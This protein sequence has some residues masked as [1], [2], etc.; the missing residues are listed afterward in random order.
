VEQ[1]EGLA[2]AG[3]QSGK[4]DTGINDDLQLLHGGIICNTTTASN[5]V[6]DGRTAPASADAPL[7]G[8]SADA[9]VRSSWTVEKR[10]PSCWDYRSNSGGSTASFWLHKAIDITERGLNRWINWNEKNACPMRY[11]PRRLAFVWI[12]MTSLPPRDVSDCCAILNSPSRITRPF[13][14]RR[15]H[16]DAN[17]H[18]LLDQCSTDPLPIPV[19]HRDLVLAHDSTFRA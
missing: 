16:C 7:C 11:M 12:T 15:P 19:D 10:P 2:T 9:V 1:A 4:E 3:A 14:T 5:Y 6:M 18:K 8:A 17:G 13:N